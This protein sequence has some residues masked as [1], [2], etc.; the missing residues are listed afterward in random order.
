MEPLERDEQTFS[1]R[2]GESHAVVV[3]PETPSVWALHR[4]DLDT[5][6]RAFGGELPGVSEEVREHHLDER[7]VADGGAARDDDDVDPPSRLLLRDGAAVVAT[8][9]RAGRRSAFASGDAPG[10]L[11]GVPLAVRERVC[12]DEWERE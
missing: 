4:L 11:A 7:G 1:V 2:R 3:D 10:P 12:V 8:A 5:G 9:D 6:I